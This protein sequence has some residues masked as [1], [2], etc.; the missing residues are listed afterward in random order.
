MKKPVNQLK[1]A[2]KHQA[3]C[4]NNRQNK[5]KPL[6]IG[7]LCLKHNKHQ[8]THKAKL[9]RPYTGPYTVLAKSGASAYFLKDRYGHRLL[10]SVPASDLVWFYD[11][12]VYRTDGMSSVILSTCSDAESDE[13]GNTQQSQDG[14][15]SETCQR[16]HTQDSQM[17]TS[18][19]KKDKGSISSQ[20]VIISSKELPVLSDD[21][22]TIDVS[23]D[24]APPSPINPRGN[25]NVNDIPIEI[26]DHFSDT[27]QE[28]LITD[29]TKKPSVYFKPLNDDDCKIASMKFNLVISEKSHKVEYRG[30]GNMCASPS[31]ITLSAQGNGACLSNSFSMLLT[32]RDTFSVIIHPVVCNYISNPVK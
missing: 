12:S 27:K 15:S 16:V 31:V 10:R 29:V 30:V 19:S 2:Q 18:T 7:D 4:Y 28:M 20:I 26:V 1:E 23:I 25:M 5:G 32:G 3:K 21:S 8:D 13:P 24:E 9:K 14:T 6:E 22:S 17:K 11:K